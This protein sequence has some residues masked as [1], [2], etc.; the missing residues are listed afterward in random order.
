MKSHFDEFTF[1]ESGIF[2]ILV[3][4]LS[5]STSVF[6][7][8]TLPSGAFYGD[9]LGYIALGKEIS[10]NSM[11][12]PS[13][14]TIHYPGSI[15]VYPPVVPYIAAI[16]VRISG[17]Y[18]L[19]MLSV[20]SVITVSLTSIPAMKLMRNLFGLREGSVGG[21]LYALYFPSLYEET[22][23][24]LPQLLAILLLLILLAIITNRQNGFRKY[25][26]AAVLFLGFL[27]PLT[28]DLTSILML[29]SIIISLLLFL[30]F[31]LA[32]SREFILTVFATMGLV[33]GISVWYLPRLWWVID[34]AFPTHNRIFSS[35][36]SVVPSSYSTGILHSLYSVQQISSA[37]A[38]IPY[39]WIPVIAF[40]VI[41]VIVLIKSVDFR[42]LPIAGPFFAL[43]FALMLFYILNPVLSARFS[44]FVYL[45]S[46]VLVTPLF[47]KV[48]TIVL[49]NAPRKLGRTDTLA[50]AIRVTS[51]VAVAALVSLSV[52]GM[53]YDAGAHSYYAYDGNQARFEYSVDAVDFLGHH[54][55]SGSVVA[56]GTIGF[57]IM[58][59]DSIPVLEYQPLNYLTQPVEW[60]ESF[61]AYEI[62]HYPAGNLSMEMIDEY[63]VS[64]VV[65]VPGI[66]DLPAFFQQVYSNPYWVIYS[67]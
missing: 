36:S 31:R 41:A 21:V 32:K 17:K 51:V 48:I 47:L 12:I 26:I 24:G 46:F 6:L 8:L 22:W 53:I 65:M 28:H 27:I 59:Y 16:F 14:N 7:L 2:T 58:A 66:H 30:T 49:R 56:N 11:V 5:A 54:Y 37:T 43:P 25:D 44:Y 62:L 50:Y 34:S 3:F 19:E 39:G 55:A 64:Y 35:L 23:G 67:V 40:F 13:V 63:H 60:N 45:F 33:A 29:A 9:L 52:S 1:A 57:M 38:L 61:A 15:W 10:I 18:A 42:H 4:L 20:F